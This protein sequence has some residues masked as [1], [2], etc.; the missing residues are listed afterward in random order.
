M[1]GVLSGILPSFCTLIKQYIFLLTIIT[2]IIYGAIY[3]H[4]GVSLSLHAAV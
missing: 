2:V 1:I 4:E 3:I